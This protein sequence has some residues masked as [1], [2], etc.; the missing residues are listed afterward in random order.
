VQ[1]SGRSVQRNQFLHFLVVLESDFGAVDDYGTK[2]NND[3]VSR[4][5]DRIPGFSPGIHP[6]S[7]V[8]SS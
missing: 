8:P 5:R 4:G 6:G 7:G 2:N 3:D 1:E